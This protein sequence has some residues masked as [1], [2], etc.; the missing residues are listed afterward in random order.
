MASRANVLRR[1]PS[2]S[3]RIPWASSC[4]PTS[5]WSGRRTPTSG[6]AAERLANTSQIERR[7]DDTTA[8]AGAV[9]TRWDTT[10]IEFLR[11]KDG[12]Q[13]ARRTHLTDMHG[14]F[15]L[16]RQ[17][18]I[19]TVTWVA[20]STVRQ[21][22]GPDDRPGPLHAQDGRRLYRPVAPVPRA[23]LD[24]PRALRARGP[25][26]TSWPG[27]SSRRSTTAPARPSR[28]ASSRPPGSRDRRP[29]HQR[30]LAQLPGCVHLEEQL[31]KANADMGNLAYVTTPAGKAT[32]KMTPIQGSRQ[33]SYVP[34]SSLGEDAG[35][36]TSTRPTRPTSCRAT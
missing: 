33:T 11:A 17:S 5:A 16:P 23:A 1:S 7:I 8:G 24:R 29:G 6:S 13:P 10:W 22:D 4:P 35:S 28:P 27:A 14:N 9:L 20:E 31:G 30:R 12:P 26:A 18:G 36:S 2:G 19:G 32:C 25:L 15:A 34:E 3:A 21:H